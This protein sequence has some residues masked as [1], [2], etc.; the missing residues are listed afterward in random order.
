MA[1][2]EELEGRFQLFNLARPDDVD[3][4]LAFLNAP[5]SAIEPIPHVSPEEDCLQIRQLQRSKSPGFD[6]IGSRIAK[7]F[8]RKGILFSTPCYVSYIFPH[9]E[10][11]L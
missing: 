10:S 5:S 11:V 9:S 1:F 4:T 8:S 7:A 6:G 3:N 2:A